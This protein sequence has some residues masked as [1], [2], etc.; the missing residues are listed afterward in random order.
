MPAGRAG[1]EFQDACA[2]QNSGPTIHSHLL[3]IQ[4]LFDAFVIVV[5]DITSSC[6]G[7]L[8]SLACMALH[9]LCNAAPLLYLGDSQGLMEVRLS[10]LP[11]PG[12]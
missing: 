10:Y 8:S 12:R 6:L 9:P 1:W 5:V 4:I 11:W 2:Q 3:N 7:H